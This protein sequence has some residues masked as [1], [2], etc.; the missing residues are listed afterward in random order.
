MDRSVSHLITIWLRT[1]RDKGGPTEVERRMGQNPNFFDG[2]SGRT[3][4]IVQQLLAEFPSDPN[5]VIMSLKTQYRLT[6]ERFNPKWRLSELLA[7]RSCPISAP[8][9]RY[10]SE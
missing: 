5:P 3:Y 9:V 10:E 8:A 4:L 6:Q 2:C 7:F 1:S